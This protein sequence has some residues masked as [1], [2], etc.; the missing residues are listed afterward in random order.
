MADPLTDTAEST[1]PPKARA[2]DDEQVG[3]VGSGFERVDGPCRG[4]VELLVWWQRIE[5]DRVA[6]CGDDYP[7][8]STEAQRDLLCHDGGLRCCRRTV[9]AHDDRARKSVLVGGVPCNEYGARRVVKHV[10]PGAAEYERTQ[11]AAGRS[12]DHNQGRVDLTGSRDELRA[13]V[14]DEKRSSRTRTLVAALAEGGP[15]LFALTGDVRRGGE[16]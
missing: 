14:A 2:A 4:P 9:V 7:K 16:P 12:A 10:V 1:G 5:V 13:R 6:A 15:S 8:R 11:S 3:L